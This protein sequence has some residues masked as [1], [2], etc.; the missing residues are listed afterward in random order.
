MRKA[1]LM[2]LHA[3][4]CG[5]VIADEHPTV[6][7][8]FHATDS[9]SLTYYCTR[10][11][12][13]KLT[14]EFV[15]TLVS[16]KAKTEELEKVIKNARES[17]KSEVKKPH[18]SCKELPEWTEIAEGRKAPPDA[19]VTLNAI[20]KRDL[21]TFVKVY[22]DLCKTETEEAYLNLVRYGHNKDMR[23]CRIGSNSFSHT[24]KYVKDSGSGA[25]AWVA[26]GAPS[27]SC[28]IVQLSR[29]ELQESDGY[30]NWNYIARK[31]ITNPGGKFELGVSCKE[32]DQGEYLYSWRR[33]E[34][35][36]GCDYIE[37][38]PSL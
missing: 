6:G 11:Q 30:K 26:Q 16:K 32:L 27:G 36:L 33:H 22:G 25:G 24:F 35:A 31:A 4:M 5:G 14:C 8:L 10:N 21:K 17:Y 13:E 7:L 15:Q 3:A 18:A 9:S 20:Q 34:N 29:F 19:S 23:T 2:L 12:D 37:F 1:V 38:V 28:G